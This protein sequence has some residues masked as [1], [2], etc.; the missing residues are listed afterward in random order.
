MWAWLH[1]FVSVTEMAEPSDLEHLEQNELKE[2]SDGELQA[3]ISVTEDMTEL[4]SVVN[5]VKTVEESSR[6][7]HQDRVWATAVSC[8]IASIPALLT[9]CT[10]GFPSVALFDLRALPPEF[11]LSTILLNLFTV[12]D[13]A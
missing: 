4:V 3:V 10:L 2:L 7:E 5:G 6:K 8:I 9:G 11:E 1:V 12:S 13:Y